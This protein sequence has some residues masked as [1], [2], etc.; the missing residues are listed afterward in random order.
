MEKKDP[1]R[2]NTQEQLYLEEKVKLKRQP[3][4]LRDD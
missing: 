3:D 4:G 1:V 2:S